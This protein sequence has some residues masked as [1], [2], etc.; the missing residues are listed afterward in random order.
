M[1]GSLHGLVACVRLPLLRDSVAARGLAA[2][3]DKTVYGGPFQDRPRDPDALSIAPRLVHA[4]FVHFEGKEWR[5]LIARTPHACT[6]QLRLA[7]RCMHCR[8]WMWSSNTCKGTI[9]CYWPNRVLPLL[10][11]PY[12]P[13][14][15]SAVLSLRLAFTR[16]PLHDMQSSM[17]TE[18]TLSLQDGRTHSRV[19]HRSPLQLTHATHCSSH[20]R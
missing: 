17:H 5:V 7:T 16:S 14:P 8:I 15:P 13:R 6:P 20:R 4:G 19:S 3:T 10:H 11:R 12:L 1:Q 9:Q 2:M 18:C